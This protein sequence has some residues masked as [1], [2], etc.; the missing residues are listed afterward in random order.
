MK[1]R[2]F[3][4]KLFQNTAQSKHLCFSYFPLYPSI[5]SFGKRF[6]LSIR[7]QS[8][9][10][11][12]IFLAVDVNLLIEHHQSVLKCPYFEYM[13]RMHKSYNEKHT[14]N[15]VN[16]PW[17]RVNILLKEEEPVIVWDDFWRLWVSGWRSSG[18]IAR[19]YWTV[20]DWRWFYHCTIQPTAL[21]L[22]NNCAE[23]E[24]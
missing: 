24:V 18:G 17:K 11:L 4:E 8:D 20:G 15:K 14:L 7:V 2:Q 3:S 6:C 21:M 9:E 22:Y 23:M 19:E 12:T 16:T 1:M 13:S 5:A 10:L